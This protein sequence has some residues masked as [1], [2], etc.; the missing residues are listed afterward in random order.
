M[1]SVSHWMSLFA[2]MGFA[3]IMV[4]CHEG[5]PS[6]GDVWYKAHEAVS[7]NALAAPTY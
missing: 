6:Y 7:V 2:L 4:P 3:L 1:A 5:R